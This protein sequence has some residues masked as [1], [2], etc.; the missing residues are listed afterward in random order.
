MHKSPK[1]TVDGIMLQKGRIVLIRR[2]NQP[3][4]GHY[5]LPGG[6]VEYGE[7]VEAAVI[8]E[9]LEETGLETKIRESGRTQARA[10]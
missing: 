1:L 8:R 5:A 6:F 2:K 7:T 10:P 3:F 9:I 4:Q